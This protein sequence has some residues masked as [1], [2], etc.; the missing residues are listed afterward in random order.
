MRLPRL[1]PLF[2]MYCIS[3][4]FG[5]EPS[6]ANVVSQAP[7]TEGEKRLLQWDLKKSFNLQ[8]ARFGSRSA[9]NLKSFSSGAFSQ[10]KTF[11]GATPF[12]SK[13][14]ATSAFPY[15]AAAETKSFSTSTSP[16]ANRGFSTRNSAPI[17][18]KEFETRNFQAQT[19]QY[20]TDSAK[21]SGRTFSGKEA[22]RAKEKYTPDNPPRGGTITGRQLSIDEVR[23][24]LNKS[25]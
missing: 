21:E 17:T 24:I 3:G 19:S 5:G 1:V 4:A 8:T 18:D 15:S 9:P 23:E 16:A 6:G 13:S 14:F 20:A 2:W 22:E 10:T 11:S 7:Q 25:K 12:E